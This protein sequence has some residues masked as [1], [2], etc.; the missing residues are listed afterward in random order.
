MRKSG[1]RIICA[2]AQADNL[3][4]ISGCKSLSYN[5]NRAA[6][7]LSTKS[8]DKSV[9]GFQPSVINLQNFA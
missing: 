7:V 8:V 9:D 1:P 6:A 4:D 3:S 2:I 5:D